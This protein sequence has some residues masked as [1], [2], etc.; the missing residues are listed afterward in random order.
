MA[1]GVETEAQ[2]SF[3]QDNGCHLMQ[4]YLFTEPLPPDV[5]ERIWRANLPVLA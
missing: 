4:G 1:E 3:L 5:L 2:R